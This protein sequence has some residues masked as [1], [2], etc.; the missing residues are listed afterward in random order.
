MGLGYLQ[1]QAKL[2][3]WYKLACMPGERYIAVQAFKQAWT[4]L[5]PRFSL[6]RAQLYA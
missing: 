4:S 2:R 3:W 1:C 6:L 5:V